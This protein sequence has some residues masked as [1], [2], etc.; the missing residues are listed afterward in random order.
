[1]TLRS[2]F[3]NQI[4]AL[5][6]S[7]KANSQEIEE[8]LGIYGLSGIQQEIEN[9]SQRINEINSYIQKLFEAKIRGEITQ[10]DFLNL[11]SQYNNEKN[12]LQNQ[13]NVLTE[14]LVSGKKNSAHIIEILNF[15]RETVFSQITQEMCDKLI[16]KVIVGVYEKN[17]AVNYGKQPIR[18]QIYEIGFIDE[19]V[20]VNYKTFRERIETVLLQRYE[21]QMVT[22]YCSEIYKEL[23]VTY[24]IM[25]KGLQRVPLSIKN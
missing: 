22:R 17:G 14:K 13:V 4:S 15:V 23:G 21:K 8:K 18:F 16:C 25:K 12:E 1:M 6:Y 3:K 9:S 19:F 5:Q 24:G 7:L 10:A 2:M 11:S 20:D